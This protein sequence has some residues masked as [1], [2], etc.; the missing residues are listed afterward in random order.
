LATRIQAAGDAERE[1][2]ATNVDPVEERDELAPYVE[3]YNEA[4]SSKDTSQLERASKRIHK[5]LSGELERRFSLTE[6]AI[7]LIAADKRRENAGVEQL[8]AA[9]MDEHRY[10]YRRIESQID[11]RDDGPAFRPSPETDR[12][13]A[14]AGSRFYIH[15]ASEELRDLL[16]VHDDRE[17]QGEVIARGE[18]I[19]GNITAVR[20]K[21]QGKT[22]IPL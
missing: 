8:M 19:S 9:S 21:K 14:A 7:E 12:H 1:S 15:E 4:R 2:I 18:A 17:M 5:V 11:D 16:L 6:R 22:S 3:M 13:P 20:E 10:Q